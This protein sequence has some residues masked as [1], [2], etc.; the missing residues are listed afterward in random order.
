MTGRKEMLDAYDKACIQAKTRKVETLHGK[1]A[2]SIFRKWLEQFLPAKYGITPGYIV[3]QGAKDKTNLPHF[4]VIIYDK[5]ESPVLWVEDDPDHSDRGKALAIP[6]EHVLAVFEVKAAMT[7]E[8]TREVV[9]KLN[10]LKP[11][12]SGTDAP[13][14]HYPKFLPRRFV[15]GSVFFEARRDDVEYSKVALNRLVDPHVV[16]R[17]DGW[18]VYNG[19]LILRGEGLRELVAGRFQLHSGETPITTSIGKNNGESM[20][21]SPLTDTIQIDEQTHVGGMLTWSE[22]NFGMWA[23]ELVGRLADRFRPGYVP[24]FHGLNFRNPKRAPVLP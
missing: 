16:R 7:T 2:E 23:F 24:S 6:A 4:D 5:L 1:V 3:S 18:T 21:G 8:S 22:A 10:E 19:A 17:E 11:L 20:F 13:D 12:V 14:Q 15:C 9:E